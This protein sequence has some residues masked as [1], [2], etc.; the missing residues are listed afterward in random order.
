MFTLGVPTAAALMAAHKKGP[1]PRDFPTY[2]TIPKYLLLWGQQHFG[3]QCLVSL[4]GNGLNSQIPVDRAN[5][6]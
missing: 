5:R 3:T 1:E 4:E 6:P 2:F